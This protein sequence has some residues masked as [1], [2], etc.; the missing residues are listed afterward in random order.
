MQ[1]LTFALVH[2]AAPILIPRHSLEHTSPCIRIK[3]NL[4]SPPLSHRHHHNFL[5]HSRRRRLDWTSIDDDE[6]P[7]HQEDVPYVIDADKEAARVHFR[8]T[9]DFQRWAAHRS[10]RRYLRHVFGMTNSRVLQGL[11]GPLLFYAA[12][13]T[14]I[15]L[16]HEL[17]D[18]EI[19][20]FPAQLHHLFVL[21]SSE[22]LSLTSVVLG[23]LL[24][25]RTN[26]SYARWLDG[27]K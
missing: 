6:T 2:R 27:M 3:H 8:T 19:I 15:G 25:F 14:A 7:P 9:F 10:T 18:A 20:V 16:G 5:V 1:Q 11:A 22:P 13:S 24:V 17:V 12:L 26:A 4:R 23:L 21:K